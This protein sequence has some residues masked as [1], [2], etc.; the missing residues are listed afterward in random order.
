[1]MGNELKTIILAA[2]TYIKTEVYRASI[3]GISQEERNRPQ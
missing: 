1:M 3:G 2:A